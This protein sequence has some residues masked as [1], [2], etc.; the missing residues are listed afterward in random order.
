MWVCIWDWVSEGIPCFTFVNFYILWGRRGNLCDC[1]GYV[2]V[3]AYI[4]Y[5]V[6]LLYG[7]NIIILV[8]YAKDSYSEWFYT[9]LI[10]FWWFCWFL[11]FSGICWYMSNYMCVWEGA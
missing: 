6:H 11:V 9:W 2:K 10:E 3:I 5:C 4:F 7:T 1:A 8:M